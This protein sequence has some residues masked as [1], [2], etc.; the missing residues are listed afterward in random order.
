MAALGV[1]SSL[2]PTF[3]RHQYH[4]RIAAVACRSFSISS[5]RWQEPQVRIIKTLDPERMDLMDQEVF[6][7]SGRP[8]PHFRVPPS[9]PD[10]FDVRYYYSKNAKCEPFPSGTIGSLYYHRPS[11][12]EPG[13]SGGLR[14][15][16]MPD[17]EAFERGEDLRLPD[18]SVWQ[19]HLCSL[20]RA[21][22]WEPIRSKLVEESLVDHSIIADL[23][24]LPLNSTGTINYH[25]ELGQPF[26][27]DVSHRGFT[28]TLINRSM[29][30]HLRWRYFSEM[31]A[32]CLDKLDVV[33]PYTGRILVRLE[34]EHLDPIG[35]GLVL[36]VLSVLKPVECLRPDYDFLRAPSPGEL[37]AHSAQLNRRWFGDSTRPLFYPLRSRKDGKD[38]ARF[39]GISWP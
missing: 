34:L 13:I 7:I 33:P 37:L 16:I 6:D 25:Y 21:K 12:L 3:R 8:C 19:V 26:E 39:A 20:A 18:D 35:P 10:T 27:L 9:T 32:G 4:G 22:R 17:A 14:F 29:A 2:L 38:I 11:L 30:C 24:K 36:R 31:Y 5:P 1:W 23:Q 28:R 15:R